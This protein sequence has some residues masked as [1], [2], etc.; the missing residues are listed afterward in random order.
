MTRFKTLFPDGCFI[1]LLGPDGAQASAR[2][3]VA[4]Q[5]R[6]KLICTD[7]IAT[8]YALFAQA[9][10]GEP[11]ITAEL[12]PLKPLLAQTCTIENLMFAGRDGSTELL[13][14]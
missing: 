9:E 14:K 1:A 2:V 12:H 10:G 4:A 8:H 13:I 3:R 7:D 5:T 6:V 11:V